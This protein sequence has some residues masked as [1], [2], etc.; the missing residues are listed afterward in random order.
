MDRMFKGQ[1]TSED[2]KWA[3]DRARLLKAARAYPN[4]DAIPC[5]HDYVSGKKPEAGQAEGF[6][7]LRDVAHGV[8]TSN[9]CEYHTGE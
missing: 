6:D 3:P 8:T 5:V 9:E 1:H 2:V 4:P 7:Y